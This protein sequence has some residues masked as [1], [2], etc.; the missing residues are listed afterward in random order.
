M[1]SINGVELKNIK[2]FGGRHGEPCLQ[3]SVYIDSKRVG[4]WSQDANGCIVDNF[5]FD[6]NILELRKEAFDNKI[7]LED[8]MCILAELKD[9]EK[10]ANSYF[11]KGFEAVTFIKEKDGCDYLYWAST[12]LPTATEIEQNIKEHFNGKECQVMSVTPTKKLDFVVKA[13]EKA[14]AFLM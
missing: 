6:T 2:K 3:G 12:R 14:P 10:E 4:F 11:R 5:D 7:R 13:T 8:F 9:Y 1:A